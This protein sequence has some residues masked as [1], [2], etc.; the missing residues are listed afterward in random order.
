MIG[1]ARLIAAGLG[2]GLVLAGLYGL[3]V[4]KSALG[5]DLFRR[6]GLHLPIPSGLRRRRR[7]PG[8]EGLRPR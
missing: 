7:R 5:I 2:T 1:P 3:Y 4:V 8:V 6:G